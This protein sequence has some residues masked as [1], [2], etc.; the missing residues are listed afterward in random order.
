MNVLV[1]YKLCIVVIAKF[2]TSKIY[3]VVVIFSSNRSN[4]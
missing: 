4:N 3:I 2:M 1:M